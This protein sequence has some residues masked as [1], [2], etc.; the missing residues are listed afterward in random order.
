LPGCR[1]G[2]LFR[3]LALGLCPTLLLGRTSL[4]RFSSSVLFF[5]ALLFSL[6]SLLLLGGS[7]ALGLC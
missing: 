2:L 1:F 3:A 6:R 4:L 7:L 5:R